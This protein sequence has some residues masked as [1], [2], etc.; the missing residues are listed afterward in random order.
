MKKNPVR[1][2]KGFT[3][4][5]I[6]AVLIILGILAAVAIPKYFDLQEDAAKAALRQ[7]V[8]ELVARD[9]LMW[10]KYKTRGDVDVDGDGTLDRPL[11]LD[12]LNDITIVVGATTDTIG[13]NTYYMFG[14]FGVDTLPTAGNATIAS[15]NF[16]MTATLA[17]TGPPA[18]GSQPGVWDTTN[19]TFTP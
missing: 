3:L 1:N 19:I 12:D 8:A 17:R 10:S 16:N 18:D 11:T 7:A 5:E 4:I 13:G 2:Q 14:D 15:K 6:I 9:N